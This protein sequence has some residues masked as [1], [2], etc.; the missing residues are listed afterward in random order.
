MAK[1][2]VLQ[3]SI[4]IACEGSNTEPLYFEKIKEIMEDE[5]DYPYALTIYPDKEIDENPKSDA[6]GLINIAKERKDQYDELWVVFDKDGYTK[7]KEAFELAEQNDIKIA[8]SSISFEMWVLLHFER[9]KE[10]F[11]KSAHIIDNKFCSN[12][13][14]LDDYNKSNEYNLYPK[15][16][17][18]TFVAFENAAWLKN[19]SRSIYPNLPI[20]ELNPY[21]DVDDIVRKLLL[22][23][24]Q[25]ECRNIGQSVEYK[26][27]RIDIIED[28]SNYIVSVTNNTNVGLVWNE[29]RFYNGKGGR[30]DIENSL[31][32]PSTSA[33]KELIKFSENEFILIEFR[34]LKL[35]VRSEN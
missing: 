24:F 17:D 32:Y 4:F 15:V 9:S 33:Q 30:I 13:S 27:V 12:E 26:G 25:Y 3:R 19:W 11:R 10:S 16:G 2:R 5:D 21:C 29:F 1:K 14:Y 6:I 8:F 23:D 20:Y 7:H 35:Q 18:R 28:V 31:I 22:C 34:G